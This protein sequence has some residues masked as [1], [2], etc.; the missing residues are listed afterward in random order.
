MTTDDP[1]DST[2]TRWFED[3]APARMPDRVLDAT[4]ERTRQSRQDIDWRARLQTLPR[5]VAALGGA[6]A[7]LVAVALALVLRP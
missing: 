1:F 5:S 3:V 7:L 6:A 4:F 2:I